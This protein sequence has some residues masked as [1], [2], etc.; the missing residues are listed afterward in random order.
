MLIPRAAIYRV[1]P[2]DI[3]APRLT[4]FVIRASFY[5]FSIV[6]FVLRLRAWS[7]ATLSSDAL[8]LCASRL[9]R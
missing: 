9:Y 7:S 6:S 8:R 3:I 2:A 5:C 1:K 4:H